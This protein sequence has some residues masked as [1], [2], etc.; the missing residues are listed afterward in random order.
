MER[1]RVRAGFVVLCNMPRADSPGIGTPLTPP[2]AAADERLDEASPGESSLSISTDHSL[3]DSLLYTLLVSAA[4]SGAAASAPA[5]GSA[6]AN[7]PPDHGNPAAAVAADL[8]A[9]LGALSQGDAAAAKDQLTTLRRDIRDYHTELAGSGRAPVHPVQT[10]KTPGA[11]AGSTTGISQGNALG[12]TP[13]STLNITQGS[14]SL[15]QLTSALSG[16]LKTGDTQGAITAIQD[17]L[18]GS[19]QASGALVN[20]LG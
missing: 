11:T 4:S 6:A 20:A 19:S 14:T 7:T 17:Y 8:S 9:L 3:Q 18:V 10:A 1:R 2:G 5:A 12:S 13:G 15:D 16:Y